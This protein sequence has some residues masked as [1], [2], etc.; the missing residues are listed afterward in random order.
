MI[1]RPMGTAY[2][3]NGNY[4]Q[5]ELRNKGMPDLTKG[6]VNRWRGNGIGEGQQHVEQMYR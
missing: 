6:Q 2:H 4:Q 5:S 1:W 3:E